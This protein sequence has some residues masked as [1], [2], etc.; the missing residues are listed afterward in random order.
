MA[1]P[2]TQGL[3]MKTSDRLSWVYLFYLFFEQ[4][5]RVQRS[6]M[7]FFVG[8]VRHEGHSFVFSTC[9]TAQNVVSA[10]HYARP[11]WQ[12]HDGPDRKLSTLRLLEI[13]YDLHPLPCY[14][15]ALASIMAA[16]GFRQSRRYTMQG[17]CV[18][19]QVSARC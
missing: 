17:R 14:L 4:M 16:L 10:R 19:T 2:S 13:K 5:N 6:E 11:N 9:R 18:Q 3:E 15:E 8:Q 1:M 7:N 12:Y